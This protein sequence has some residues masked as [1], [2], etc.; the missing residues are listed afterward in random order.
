MTKTLHLNITG[1]HCSAC[2]SSIENGLL[3]KSGV[4]RAQVSLVLGAATVDFDD[5]TISESS[6]LDHV[7]A[8]G[9]QAAKGE[10]SLFEKQ[11]QELHEAKDRAKL[12]AALA[13]PLFLLAMLPMVVPQLE[14][15]IHNSPLAMTL[16][17]ILQAALAGLL[18]MWPGRLI[19]SDAFLRLRHFEANMNTLIATGTLAA[20]GW[21]CWLLFQGNG[22]HQHFYFESAGVI[23]AIVLFGHYLE[24]RS[25]QSAGSALHALLALRPKSATVLVNGV[26]LE[27]ESDA[28]QPEMIVIVRPGDRLPADGVVTEGNPEIDEALVTGESQPVLKQLGDR[29]IGGSMNG[30][31]AFQYRVTKHAGES[32]LADVVRLVSRAQMEKAPLQRL[33]DRIA[34]IFVPVVFGISFLTGL[35]WNVFAPGN[36]GW[37]EAMIAVLIVACPCALGLATPTA[38]LVAS[39]NAARRGMIVRSGEI[40]ERLARIKAILFD[41]TGTLTTGSFSIQSII[42]ADRVEQ[43]E[44]LRIAASVSASSNHPLS[45]SIVAEAQTRGIAFH[46]PMMVRQASGRGTSG[47]IDNAK[48]AIGSR[49]FVSSALHLEESDVSIHLTH[50]IEKGSEVWVGHGNRLLG[51]IYLDDTIRSES[52]TEIR[53]LRANYQVALL[54]GDK[55][56]RVMLFAKSVGIAEAQGGLTPSTKLDAIASFKSKHGDVAMVGDGIN[57]APA[58]ARADVGIAMG[59]GA[60]VALASADVVLSRPDLRLIRESLRLGTRTVDVIKQNL[61]WAFIYNLLC[62]PLAAGLFYPL[63]GWMLSPMIAA[64]LM[65]L[66]SLFVVSNALRLSR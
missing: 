25:K 51:V 17:P 32:F 6:I 30:S 53:A 16:S 34:G 23:I 59:S 10:P 56:E 28:I 3:T 61:F 55:T 15:L 62:I 57:D 54:S 33:A 12:A 41:K 52:E 11:L 49:E 40:F 39:G 27:L 46:P 58:L 37:I 13:I 60:D 2:V 43:T 47:M 44:L 19:L 9:Y 38:I 65:A 66:S 26:Q 50:S 42:V 5:T 7:N 63:T 18:L 14:K 24:A 45:R 48:A 20:F 31:V 22:A 4:Q 36:P 8:L 21:S 64:V 1:M 35:L 29:V